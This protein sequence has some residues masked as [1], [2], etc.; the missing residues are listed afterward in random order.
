HYRAAS[1]GKAKVEGVF[2]RI[3]E[4]QCKYFVAAAN[5]VGKSD[6]RLG[7]QLE[8]LPTESLGERL[9]VAIVAGEVVGP[10]KARERLL[11]EEHPTPEVAQGMILGGAGQVALAALQ[12]EARQR[13]LAEILDRLY[14]DLERKEF[15]FPSVPEAE[16]QRLRDEL[17]WFGE[18]ALT[19]A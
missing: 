1:R 15:D 8:A 3:L 16:R 17:G 13:V 19:P 4:F 18:L 6:P 7:Q 10:E 12:R 11:L 14:G 2:P 5:M 9:R